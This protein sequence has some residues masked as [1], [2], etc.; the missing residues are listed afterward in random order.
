[1]PNTRKMGFCSPMMRVVGISCVL[2]DVSVPEFVLDYVVYHESLHLVQGYIP[3]QRAH[4]REFREKEKMYP[5]YE[6]AEKCLR[7]LAERK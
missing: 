5:R 6:E 4:S 7:T 1:M 2:D 3:G